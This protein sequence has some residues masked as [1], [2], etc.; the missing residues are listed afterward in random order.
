MKEITTEMHNW[1]VN[2]VQGTCTFAHT[3]NLEFNKDF[4]LPEDDEETFD[5]A[6]KDAEIFECGSCG[7]FYEISE[8]SD[9]EECEL[10]CQD[11]ADCE[12]E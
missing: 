1:I 8:Q 10:V 12:E 2:H 4:G 9:N 5:A 7:W 11:C 3:H 6:M